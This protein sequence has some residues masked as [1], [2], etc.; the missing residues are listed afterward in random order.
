MET[1]KV[2][3]NDKEIEI[4]TSMEPEEYEDFDPTPDLEK[5]LDLSMDLDATIE[6]EPKTFE[7]GNFNDAR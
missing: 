5:T 7:E 1:K 6:I 4:V 3:V 2:V